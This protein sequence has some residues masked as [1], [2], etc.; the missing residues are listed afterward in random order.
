MTTLRSV[1]RLTGMAALSLAGGC[2]YLRAANATPE[3]MEGQLTATLRQADQEAVALRFGV[4]DRLLAEFAE[5]HV[6]AP[7]AVET[8]FWRAVFKLDTANQTGSRR[9][10]LALLDGY[11]TAPTAVAHRG[12]ALA[13]RRAASERPVVVA[14]GPTTPATPS[15]APSPRS[16]ANAEEVQRLREELAKAN[17]E[18]ERIRKRLSQPNP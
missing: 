7:E 1:G 16:E 2:A 9:D 11:L 6:G 12:A 15:T 14:P 17:A 3:P 4:A 10:A 5:S 13:L 8:A 18:L